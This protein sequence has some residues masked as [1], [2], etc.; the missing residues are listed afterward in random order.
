LTADW[1]LPGEAPRN[2]FS[3]IPS[4]SRPSAF[5][6]LVQSSIGVLPLVFACAGDDTP[7][8]G[9]NAGDSSSAAN[10]GMS[11]G[12]GAGSGGSTGL[13]TGGASAG[14]Q[15][16][17]TG[18]GTQGSSGAGAAG[19]LDGTGMGGTADAGRGNAAAG[20]G[21]GTAARSGTGGTQGNAG[22][23]AADDGGSDGGRA[24]G[25]RGATGGTDASAGNG[26]GRG[27]NGAAGAAGAAGSSGTTPDCNSV[28]GQ[29]VIDVAADGSGDF[30]TVQ[31]AVNS[32]ASSNTTP[33]QIR[34][35]PGTYKE[36]L[37]VNRP[38]V[39][40]CGQAG[41]ASSTILTY[42]DNA[43]T[44]DGKGG[45]LGTSGGTSTNISASNVA[46]ENITF[47]NSTAL[48]GSQA[49]ALLVTGSRVQFRNCRFLSYQDTLYVKSGSQYFK[50]CY[51]E[52]SVD[53]IFGAATAVFDG[54]TVHNAAS[55]V[56]A[57]APNTD[58]ATKYGLVFLGGELT[59]D[60][61]IS[62]V[63]LGRNWGAY[64]AATYVKTTLGAHINPVGWLAMGSNTLDTARFAE[65]QTTGSGASSANLAKRAS[66]SK[67]LTS[68]EASAYTVAGVLA[69]WTPSFSE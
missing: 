27:G 25:G 14:H 31:A 19:G 44:S 16:G 47:A 22:R 6:R 15:A 55:G 43:N 61:G 67:Q 46:A 1:R 41:Q 52:G 69:P 50:S 66:Q 13:G 42:S 65:F 57:T 29:P 63:A 8:T 32:V 24:A 7:G 17:G 21:A 37:I 35:K 30:T 60:S 26:A 18:G 68:S 9:G 39:T 34:I 28:T 11:A 48:G 12:R 56:A 49:V 3:V 58:Q 59:A 45:T 51:V 4:G 36:K 64:G 20:A 54:C 2:L 38:Y 5:L 33:T 53:F 40:F 23:G 62:N 10:G